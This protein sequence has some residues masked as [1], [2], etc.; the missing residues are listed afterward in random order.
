MKTNRLTGTAVAFLSA[1]FIVSPSFAVTATDTVPATETATTVDEKIQGIKDE[2]KKAV[3]ERLQNVINQDTKKG[4]VGIIKSKDAT[5]L[6]IEDKQGNQKEI[7]YDDETIVISEN[8][9]TLE[10]D[11][12]VV[13]KNILAMGYLQSTKTLEGKRVIFVDEEKRNET[14][15]VIGLISDKSV[16]TK[17]VVITP[18]KDKNE[19]IEMEINTKTDIILSDGNQGDYDDLEVSQKIVVVFENVSKQKIAKAIKIIP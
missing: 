7:L 6:T 19:V 11:D 12:L 18:L 10:I 5:S 3:K 17:L 15:S 13:G 16:E 4:W 8:R 14:Q 9:Q 1:F 2:A